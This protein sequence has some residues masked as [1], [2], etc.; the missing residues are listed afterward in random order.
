M[1][2]GSRDLPESNTQRAVKL[3]SK[4]HGVRW[5]KC[6]LPFVASINCIRTSGNASLC[7]AGK[8]FTQGID[9]IL[10]RLLKETVLGQK[11]SCPRAV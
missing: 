4:A 10:A 5:D 7:Y 3:W 8:N 6:I 11:E 1:T 9:M 2:Y